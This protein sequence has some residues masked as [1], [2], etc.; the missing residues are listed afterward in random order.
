MEGYELSCDSELFDET[1]VRFSG[2]AVAK[3]INASND[4]YMMGLTVSQFSYSDT[5]VTA[6][7]EITDGWLK[8]EPENLTIHVIG[9]TDT[10]IFNGLEQKA[11][12]Y[13]LSCDDKIYDESK[14]TFSGEAVAKGTDASDKKYMMGL[15]ASKFSYNDPNVMAAFEVMDGWLKIDPAV[16]T[17]S[18]NGNSDSRVYN[19]KEQRV[20][21]YDLSCDN[22]LYD[23][24]KVVFSG[25]AVAKGTEV[26]TYPMDLSAEKFSYEDKNVTARYLVTDG[27]LKIEPK[28][29]PDVEPEDDPDVEPEDD[30]DVEP[31]HDPDVEPEH[32][33]DVVPGG[34]PDVVPG[35]DP[36]VVPEDKPEV[37]PEGEPDKN[38]PDGLLTIRYVLNGGTYNG[39][40]EDIVETY[41]YGTVISI[42]EAPVREGYTFSHWEGS[43][44]YPGDPYTVTE[45]HTFVAQWGRVEGAM[46]SP[47]TGDDHRPGLW[48][49]T[50]IISLMGLC[51][52][53]VG[54][55]RRKRK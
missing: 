32:D 55:L 36:D 34:D 26:G 5:S 4:N 44:Y 20:E 48:L 29:E 3:G 17:I 22:E 47:R 40:K 28:G 42:H 6:K 16:L 1:K 2:E 14:V 24:S 21:G 8:I 41:P 53:G 38:T 30:P 51:F 19:G 43:K 45:D 46:L 13:D 23:K 12:G 35:G 33:P 50:M 39:S 11:E 52:S 25:E 49:A 7:F 9:S 10:K 18:V 15:G 27:W 31:E 37:I 54:Y